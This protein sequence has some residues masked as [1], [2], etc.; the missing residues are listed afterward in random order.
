VVS[1]RYF[2]PVVL[3]LAELGRGSIRNGVF[4]QVSGMLP[5]RLGV[6]GTSAPGR[7]SSD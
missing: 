4:P 2:V 5:R 6:R 3:L 7:R 1:F